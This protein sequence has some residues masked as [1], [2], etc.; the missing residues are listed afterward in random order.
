M[1]KK[2]LIYVLIVVEAWMK[3]GLNRFDSFQEFRI[4]AQILCLINFELVFE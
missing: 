2:K 4:N 3:F 1:F